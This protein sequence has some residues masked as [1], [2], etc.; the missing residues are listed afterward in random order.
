MQIMKHLIILILII[1]PIS[2][3]L[4]QQEIVYFNHTQ[5]GFIIGEES[6]DNIQKA[7]IP[8]FQTINGIR[9]GA[10]WGIGIGV[11]AEPFE[12]KVYPIFF[13]IHHFFNTKLK[14]SPF[15]AIKLGHGFSDSKKKIVN[16]GYGGE[17]KH[18]GGL[19]FNPE[20]GFRF[21]MFD[22]EM[23]LS[24]GYRFQRLKSKSSL[25]GIPSNYIYD[26]QVEYNR[27]AFAIGVVF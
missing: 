15:F 4:A 11:G 21:K 23:T 27:A 17:F 18:K 5:V 10:N 8:S 24:G 20:I 19:M 9:I 14:N 26:H 25:N 13:S 2:G 7:T 12:Y 6:E 16:Y 3:L 22:F 1:S